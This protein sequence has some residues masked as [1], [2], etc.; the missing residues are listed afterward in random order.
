MVP[1]SQIGGLFH[2][3]SDN[4]APEQARHKQCANND[5]LRHSTFINL[6]SVFSTRL[7]IFHISTGFFMSSEKPWLLWVNILPY[8]PDF[9]RENASNLSF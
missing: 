1:P 9:H 2:Q 4:E 3:V 6:F 5:T 8:R 7:Q